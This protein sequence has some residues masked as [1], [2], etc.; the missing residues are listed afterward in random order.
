ME[1]LGER[2]RDERRNRKLTLEELSQKTELSKSFLSQIERGLAQPSVSSLKK[3][4]QQ[5]GISVVNLFTNE[6][7]TSPAL[8]NPSTL[9]GG[10]ISQ[11][12]YVEEVKV[13]RRARRKTLSLPGS[14]VSYDLITP[15]LNR[16]IEILF[17]RLS[18]GES[19]GNEP[20]TDPPGEK[21]CLILK[22]TLEYRVGEEAYELKEGDSIYHP[23]HL[24]HSW[25]GIGNEPIE[26]I[27]VLSP[28]SF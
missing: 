14:K 16:Q 11:P 12:S 27:V 28:P 13:V 22:G 21:C 19:S 8:K 25:Y 5:F 10:K 3:I 26:V 24:P 1:N 17:L 7:T 2:I 4:A 6:S 23:A 15:D 20:I 18:P 9:E